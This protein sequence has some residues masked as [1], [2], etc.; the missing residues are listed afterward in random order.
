MDV[1]IRGERLLIDIDFKSKFEIARATKTYKSMLQ[2][3]PCIFVGKADRL[4]RIVVLI[5]KAAKQS[6][7]KKGLHVPPWRRA[8][9][10]KSKWLSSHVRVDQ[11]PDEEVKQDSVGMINESIGSVVFGV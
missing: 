8:E 9:Y 7:K 11:N 2:T 6:L 4:Q 3:L 10:V 1:I 5:C